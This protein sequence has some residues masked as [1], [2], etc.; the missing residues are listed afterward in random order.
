MSNPVTPTNS[1]TRSGESPPPLEQAEH[2]NSAPRILIVDDIDAIHEDFRKILAPEARSE[3]LGDIEAVIFGEKTSKCPQ[4]R[5]EL[6]SAFQ[7]EQAVELVRDA[8]REGRSFSL[9]FVDMRMPPGI[10]GLET[11]VNMWEH[12]PDLQV[13]IS[14][15]YSDYTWA[16]IYTRLGHS[17]RFLLLRKPFDNAEVLQQACGLT[18]KWQLAR[19]ASLRMSELERMVVE[20]T[21]VLRGEIS[22]RRAAEAK[23]RHAATH[24]MLTGLV[25]RSHLIER[26]QRCIERRRREDGFGYAVLFLDCDDFKSINDSLGHEFGDELL[27][28][29][30][31]RLVATLRR[32]DSVVRAEGDITA[33]FGGDEFVVLLTGLKRESEATVVAERITRHMAEPF[34]LRGTEVHTSVSLGIAIGADRHNTSDE[35]IQDADAAMYRAK[36]SGKAAHAV[37]DEH[38]FEHQVQRLRL[39][40]ELRKALELGQFRVVYEPIV[41]LKSH[42]LIALEALLRWAHP[43]R[44]LL[45]P[46]DFLRVAEEAG[47]LVPIGQWVMNEA[48]TQL[49]EWRQSLDGVDHVRMTVNISKK[50]LRSPAFVQSLEKTLEQTGLPGDRLTLDVTEEAVITDLDAAAETLLAAKQFGVEIHM[51]DF[52]TGLSSLA[53][54]HKLP[55]DGVKIDRAFIAHLGSARE[56]DA[57]V[58]AVLAL[59]QHLNKK[60]IAE[61]V[62]SQEQ[63]EQL[64]KLG[65]DFIQ[66]Y[67]ITKPVE[68]EHAARMLSG[69]FPWSSAA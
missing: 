64:L 13:V 10:D 40:N 55:I 58:Y 26:I 56:Y 5:F 52:G 60:V 33:R 18:A 35:L 24:D 51:D 20:R 12:D 46:A 59:A 54:L 17:D 44:G 25:N 62:E 30:A 22:E 1:D 29:L 42:S 28:A 36:S 9:A 37:F 6:V 27:K 69:S 38:L 32:L 63:V 2:A 43:T 66:G 23:L 11:V 45:P 41:D 21:S 7:G 14:S 31:E 4:F 19:Q 49:V 48:C 16:E 47:L 68:P 39:E 53:F 8:Q 65:C 3:E 15:A 67:H 61:G 34:V 50:Q 57:I